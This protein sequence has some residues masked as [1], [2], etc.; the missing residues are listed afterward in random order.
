MPQNR[1][2]DLSAPCKQ[3]TTQIYLLFTNTDNTNNQN[4]QEHCIVVIYNCVLSMMN[5]TYTGSKHN[6][7]LVVIDHK[8]EIA[9]EILKNLMG[10]HR[11]S[12]TQSAVGLDNKHGL[13]ANLWKPI[14]LVECAQIVQSS[15]E[16]AVHIIQTT[17][18]P[19]ILKS[20]IYG[21]VQ[22]SYMTNFNRFI[23]LVTLVETTSKCCVCL[24]SINHTQN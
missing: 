18:Q 3:F 6:T 2:T 10:R 22:K 23:L 11:A 13:I 17:E 16:N 21:L 7:R 19:A 12:V 24:R 4:F 14:L 1:F 5:L 9:L 8:P 15:K 20:W